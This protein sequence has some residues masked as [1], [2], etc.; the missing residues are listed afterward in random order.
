MHY[1]SKNQKYLRYKNKKTFTLLELIVAIS[2]LAISL[3]G[4]M[5]MSTSSKKRIN[6]AFT[7]WN[8]QHMLSQA[9]EFYLLAGANAQIPDEIFPY[10]NVSVSCNISENS[11]LPQNVDNI[12]GDW[13]LSTYNIEL[14]NSGGNNLKTIKI[15]KIL[16]KNEL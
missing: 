13:M 12:S 10:E 7:N 4:A 9:A 6:K 15:D 8:K 11:S 3:V 2:I 1:T 5:S 14:T 16:N